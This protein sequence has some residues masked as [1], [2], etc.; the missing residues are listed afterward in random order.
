MVTI[1]NTLEQL[2]IPTTTPP[3]LQNLIKTME[4]LDIWSTESAETNA[5]QSQIY[6]QMAERYAMAAKIALAEF[7][8]MAED[9]IDDQR[10]I[11]PQSKLDASEEEFVKIDKARES[12]EQFLVKSAIKKKLEYNS[13]RKPSENTEKQQRELAKVGAGGGGVPIH[14]VK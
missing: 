1:A 6:Q 10:S 13:T 14:L 11:F 4:N 12:V 2:R 7:L 9:E 8:I 3:N 5:I